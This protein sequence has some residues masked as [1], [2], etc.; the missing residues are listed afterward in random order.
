MV[1]IIHLNGDPHEQTQ[2][3]LPWYV[4][5]TLAEGETEQVEKH[6]SE[7]AECRED[8][9]LERAL[10]GQIKILP[11]SADNGWEK[12]RARIE[13]AP[14][15]SGKIAPFRRKIPLWWA[16]A[17]QAASF[18]ILV[19][20]I[21]TPLTRPAPP[22]YRTLGSAPAAA[23][24]N[25]VVMFKPEASEAALRQILTQNQA[26]IVDGPTAAGA[27]VLHVDAERRQ[28][29]L[30]RLKGDRNVSLAEPIDGD[31]R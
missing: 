25:V 16:L 15:A 14:A 24:G 31:N 13:D 21:A 17:A 27:Y 10:A 26:R 4:N 28:A 11:G 30:T 5:G 19:P 8:I 12:I 3:L 20:L 7:C 1:D 29:V 9:A 6:L 23:V 22:L 2:L 18:A